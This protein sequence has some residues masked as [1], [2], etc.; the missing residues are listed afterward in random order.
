M[1]LVEGDK[2]IQIMLLAT[3]LI[4][5]EARMDI[6]VNLVKISKSSNAHVGLLDYVDYYV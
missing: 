4:V 6:L 3:Y 5:F 1:Q 2:Q